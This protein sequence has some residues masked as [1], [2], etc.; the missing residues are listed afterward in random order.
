[1]NQNVINICFVRKWHIYLSGTE[2]WQL[3]NFWTTFQ[4][5]FIIRRNKMQTLKLVLRWNR[6]GFFGFF[7]QFAI[8]NF[9]VWGLRFAIFDLRWTSFLKA[10]DLSANRRR[11]TAGSTSA[12]PARP[13]PSSS[14]TSGPS[15]SAYLWSRQESFF[16]TTLG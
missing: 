11:Y 16:T 9:V 10:F 4:N 2:I 12:G 7:L 14:S 5:C 15:S 1:M 13:P 8:C 6:L 3:K